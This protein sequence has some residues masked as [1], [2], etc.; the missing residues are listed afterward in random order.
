[1]PAFKYVGPF[2]E[3]VLPLV[4]AVR[5]GESVEVPDELVEGLV[6]EHWSAV[7]AKAS[8]KTKPAEG[9]EES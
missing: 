8:A 6:P 1:M 5:Q 2:D 9:T 4:G 7:K 3:V